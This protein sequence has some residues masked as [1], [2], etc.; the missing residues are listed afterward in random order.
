MRADAMFKM[1]V[2]VRIFKEG[3]AYVAHCP[4]FDVVSQGKSESEARK[5]ITE[6][7]VLFVETCYSNGTLDTVLKQSGFKR[8]PDVVIRT[9][10]ICLDKDQKMVT[11]PVHLLMQQNNRLQECQNA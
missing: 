8:D 6:A 9:K 2:P 11:V 10:D 5:N 4:I 1:R 7:L 3:S